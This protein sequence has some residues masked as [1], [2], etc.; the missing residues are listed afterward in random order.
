MAPRP[1]VVPPP[2]SLP[3]S[4]APGP[5]GQLDGLRLVGLGVFP[6]AE[7]HGRPPL[8]A[9]AL[10]EEQVA[11]VGLGDVLGVVEVL[12]VEQ[13]RR[14]Q[15]GHLRLGLEPQLGGEGALGRQRRVEL[16]DLRPFRLV[17]R[18]REAFEAGAE[19][20]VFRDPRL[21]AQLEVA[22]LPR[23]IRRL[24]PLVEL[25]EREHGVARGLLSRVRPLP[26]LLLPLRRRRQSNGDEQARD[27]GPTAQP[28]LPSVFIRVHLWFHSSSV[29]RVLRARYL[30]T[31]M[32]TGFQMPPA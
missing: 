5:R 22:P 19:P 27:R 17:L 6:E 15:V 4:R 3:S 11:C 20:A 16:H 1:A 13:P 9:A 12:A 23:R 18:R 7:H 2:M 32:R 29:C 24:R 26:G 30:S 21:P 10:E 14:P 8:L 28:S 31:S 25:P